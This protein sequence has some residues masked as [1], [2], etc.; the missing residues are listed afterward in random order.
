MAIGMAENI[1]NAFRNGEC[2]L[3][4]ARVYE[5]TQKHNDEARM[6]RRFPSDTESAVGEPS[7]F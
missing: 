7:A 2:L 6:Q 3:S 5:N 1:Y 4:L